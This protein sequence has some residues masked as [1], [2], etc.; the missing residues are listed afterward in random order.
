MSVLRVALTGGIATGKSHCLKR[1]ASLG[2]ETIDADLLA[3]QAV[4][5]GSLNFEAVLRRFGRSILGADGGLDRSALGQIVFQDA[6]ARRDLEAIIHPVVYSAISSWFE[7]LDR[8]SRDDGGEIVAIAD[9]PLLFETDRHHDFEQVVVAACPPDQQLERLI[10]RGFSREAAARQI[11][12]QLP[13]EEKAGRG[14]FV[15]DTSG[16]LAK[17]D[18]QVDRV[19]TAL[20]SLAGARR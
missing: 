16:T 14:D 11:A 10:A 19:W 8:R 13:I 5:P 20:S 18:A 6:A 2:A 9:I 17:T 7:T 12:A 1:F 4:R 15:I 3:R